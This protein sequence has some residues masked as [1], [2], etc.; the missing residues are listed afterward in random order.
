DALHFSVDGGS[1]ATDDP[2]RVDSRVEAA[3]ADAALVRRVGRGDRVALGEL[4]DHHATRAY[5]LACQLV[6]AAAALDGVHDAFGALIDKPSTYDPA[7]GSFQAWFLTSV[8][9]RCLNLRR[10]QRPT[11]S[12]NSLAELA[13]G[14]AD[15]ADAVVARLRDRAVRDALRAI[16]H[17]QREVLV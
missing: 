16:G 7:R 6:G 9:H 10:S 4:Y 15:P 3:R 14:E 13:S 1:E 2:G 12:E 5:S 17:D 11:L 8:H